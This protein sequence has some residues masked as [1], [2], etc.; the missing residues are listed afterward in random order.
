VLATKVELVDVLVV[1]E[2]LELVETEDEDVG[3]LVELLEVEVLVTLELVEILELVE[4]LELVEILELELVVVNDEEDEDDV[5]EVEHDTVHA[6]A[7]P[8]SM[9]SCQPPF[10]Q[11]VRIEAEDPVT[12][13]LNVSGIVMLP[14]AAMVA[15]LAGKLV[16]V[17]ALPTTVELPEVVTFWYG[18]S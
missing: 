8:T 10:D 15:P 9:T 11:K 1:L 7:L 17:K 6:D 4:T 12:E 14:P 16:A 5:V 18:A 13:G 3:M 2:T